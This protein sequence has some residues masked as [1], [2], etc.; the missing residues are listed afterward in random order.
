[1]LL[2]PSLFL[3]SMQALLAAQ[4]S[5]HLCS[6]YYYGQK[7]KSARGG[8]LC[9]PESMANFLGGDGLTTALSMRHSPNFGELCHG[10]ATLYLTFLTVTSFFP[11]TEL[12]S[13]GIIE[14]ILKS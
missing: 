11:V 12:L 14:L 9:C 10:Q 13:L 3:G 1:M 8:M 7:W 5:L 4:L 2:L 6:Y